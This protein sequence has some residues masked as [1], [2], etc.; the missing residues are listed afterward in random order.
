M[1]QW[2]SR[3]RRARTRLSGR[4]WAGHGSVPTGQ[5]AFLCRP[6]VRGAAGRPGRAGRCPGALCVPRRGSRTAR[7][8]PHC[9]GERVFVWGR[10]AGRAPLSAFPAVPARP[11]RCR[12]RAQRGAGPLPWR[13]A[14]TCG[15]GGGGADARRGGAG[16]RRSRGCRHLPHTSSS[17][18]GSSAGLCGAAGAP[19]PGPTQALSPNGE[20]N[21]DIIQDNGTIIPFRKHTV[22]GER[23]YRYG[24]GAAA[25]VA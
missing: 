3:S 4:R 24:G 5:A 11:A 25:G 20:N 14:V 15:G 16:G 22:R 12:P 7:A 23:S 19:M 21:N 13:G 18:S 1:R 9:R 8:A 17:S 10:G 6:R 2:P